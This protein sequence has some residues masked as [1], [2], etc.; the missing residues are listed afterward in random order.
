ME[1]FRQCVCGITHGKG[2][3]LACRPHTNSP[4]ECVATYRSSYTRILRY[5]EIKLGIIKLSMVV[6]EV[7]LDLS[8]FTLRIALEVGIYHPH[9]NECN[10][11]F[12]K[13]VWVG[14]VLVWFTH[15]HDQDLEFQFVG[16]KESGEGSCV[17][18][19]HVFFFPS[20]YYPFHELFTYVQYTI[21]PI[22]VSLFCSTEVLIFLLALV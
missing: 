11:S 10:P 20:V 14:N 19:Y 17:V 7:R 21:F 5:S 8:C 6:S 2:C 22:F 3:H 15:V 16:T 4:F 18:I 1:K 9:E 12:K 13:K